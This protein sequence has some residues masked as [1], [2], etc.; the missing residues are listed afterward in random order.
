LRE[1]LVKG[2][3]ALREVILSDPKG[4]PWF[5]TAKSRM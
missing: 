4:Q 1:G 3:A 2:V 5:E